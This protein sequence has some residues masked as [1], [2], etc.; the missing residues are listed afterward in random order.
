MDAARS[1]IA[2][3]VVQRAPGRMVKNKSNKVLFL[4][5]DNSGESEEVEVILSNYSKGGRIYLVNAEPGKYAV[6]A[7]Y[8][9]SGFRCGLTFFS[10]EALKVSE[11]DVKPGE[12]A[13]IGKFVIDN[14][15]KLSTRGDETQKENFSRFKGIRHRKEIKRLFK[16]LTG[17]NRVGSMYRGTLNKYDR[18][19]RSVK[20][21]LMKAGKDFKKTR[22]L[23]MFNMGTRRIKNGT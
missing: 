18:T 19:A 11:I 7:A 15:L 6:M 17:F 1:I 22:W 12:F 2:V 20:E 8:Y 16:G 23:E 9:D 4:K 14:H 10:R 21:S 3:S 13:F 5:I